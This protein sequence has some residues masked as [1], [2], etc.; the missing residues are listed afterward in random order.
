MNL[1]DTARVLGE[2]VNKSIIIA[3]K[4]IGTKLFLGLAIIAVAIYSKR[5]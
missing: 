2:T 3:G 4:D 5:R 1:N